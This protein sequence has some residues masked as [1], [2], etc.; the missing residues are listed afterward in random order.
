MC[1]G[2]IGTGEGSEIYAPLGQAIA[3]GLLA[4]TAIAL[5][6]M[7]VLYYILERRKL[8]TTYRKQKETEVTTYETV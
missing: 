3:G 5:F 1:P 7:P 6:L 4:T 2:Q 8:K